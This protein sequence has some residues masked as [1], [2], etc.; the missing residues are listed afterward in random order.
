MMNFQTNSKTDRI[1]SAA[2]MCFK[3]YGFKR[4]SMADIANQAEMSRPALYLLFKNKTDIFRS[5]SERFH[6]QTLEDAKETL[7]KN[8]EIRAKVTF[9][10]IARKAPIYALAHDSLHGP[11]LFDVNISTASDINQHAN[12]RFTT[13][14]Q[15]VLSGAVHDGLITLPSGV[16]TQDLAMMIYAGAFG[17]TQS[18]QNIEHYKDLLE[19]LVHTILAGMLPE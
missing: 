5:L 17:L 10:L 4:T 2:L 18:A 19:K 1:L 7:G 16:S 14:L 15:S 11:E 6:D 9:M 8:H 13:L 12:D 3:Q